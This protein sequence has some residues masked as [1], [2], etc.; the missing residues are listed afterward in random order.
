VVETKQK[1]GRKWM[2]SATA[3]DDEE[4]GFED[5]DDDGVQ[6]LFTTAFA[7]QGPRFRARLRYHV[8]NQVPNKL[9]LS[10]ARARSFSHAR[11]RACACAYSPTRRG[12]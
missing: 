1:K 9:C 7:Q 10:R 12:G 2:Q 11:K 4:K 3:R 8:L 5:E 6:K